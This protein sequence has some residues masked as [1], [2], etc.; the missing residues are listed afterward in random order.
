[1]SLGSTRPWGLCGLYRPET[2]VCTLGHFTL[3]GARARALGAKRPL[4]HM[5][6]FSIV[7]RVSAE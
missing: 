4:S 3:E 5:S 1:V 7:L 6:L 2:R